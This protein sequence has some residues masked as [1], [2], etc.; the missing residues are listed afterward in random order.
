MYFVEGGMVAGKDGRIVLVTCESMRQ[1]QKIANV[2]V[3]KRLA[4]CVNILGGVIQSVYRWKG[5][6]ENA[7]EI[8]MVIKTTKRRLAELE[9]EVKRLHSYDVPEFVVLPI[10]A[11]SR[12]Y[13]GWLE[14]SVKA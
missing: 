6:V 2:V 5:S 10:A 13:L 11:G 7:K 3:E 8:L 12:Q 9:R 14:E 1:A 4:A